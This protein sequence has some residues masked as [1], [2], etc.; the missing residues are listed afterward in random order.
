[1]TMEHHVINKH[2]V[3]EGYSKLGKTLESIAKGKLD[4]LQCVWKDTIRDGKF[5]M[6][7]WALRNNRKM[8]QCEWWL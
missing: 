5:D 3:G 4:L 6:R 8:Y 2:Q 7:M 1:M